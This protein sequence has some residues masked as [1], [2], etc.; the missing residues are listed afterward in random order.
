[1]IIIKFH[2]FLLMFFEIKKVSHHFSL[3]A[4]PKFSRS[5][6]NNSLIYCSN[7]PLFIL[8]SCYSWF[9]YSFSSTSAIAFAMFHKSSFAVLIAFIG[10]RIAFILELNIF[11][12]EMSIA[13]PLFLYL[14]SLHPWAPYKLWSCIFSL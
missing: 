14:I 8:E 12:W 3:S 5:A 9:K 4:F 10:N 2:I 6:T 13:L 11:F 1:M 7:S